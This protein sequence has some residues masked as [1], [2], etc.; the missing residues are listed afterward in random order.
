MT[1]VGKQYHCLTAEV[2]LYTRLQTTF[3]GSG[4]RQVTR[5]RAS[6]RSVDQS[7]DAHVENCLMFDAWC[8]TYGQ[9]IQTFVANTT[10][11]ART[12]LKDTMCPDTREIYADG[13]KIEQTSLNIAKKFYMCQLAIRNG[14][15]RRGYEVASDFI[16]YVGF[17][18]ALEYHRENGTVAFGLKSGA[19]VLPRTSGYL[20]HMSEIGFLAAHTGNPFGEYRCMSTAMRDGDAI[21]EFMT[22]L[23]S[24]ALF[25]ARSESR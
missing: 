13:W 8:R 11:E 21:R 12:L 17:G 2:A 23:G 22:Y 18:P 9:D 4:Y 7:Y 25:V 14:F 16:D 6:F 15:T 10:P 19:E 24:D 5:H 3:V 20:T 1:A